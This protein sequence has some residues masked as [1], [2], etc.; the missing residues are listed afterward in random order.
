MSRILQPE[1]LL[2][3]LASLLLALLAWQGK[4][5]CERVAGLE[6]NQVRIMVHLGIEPIAGEN[7]LNLGAWGSLAAAAEYQRNQTRL[8]VP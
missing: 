4:S 2:K 8:A 5:L 6:V 3:V 1:Y 7:P